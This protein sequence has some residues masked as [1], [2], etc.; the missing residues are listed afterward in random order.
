MQGEDDMDEFISSDHPLVSRVTN[1]I[2]KHFATGVHYL[3][4]ASKSGLT[5]DLALHLASSDPAL[6]AMLEQSKDRTRT[7]AIDVIE[8]PSPKKNRGSPTEIKHG[9][10]KDLAAAGLFAKS[11]K[12]VRAADPDTDIGA[13]VIEG[14]LRFVVKELWPRESQTEHTE[15]IAIE[16]ATEAELEKK[17]ALVRERR[18]EAQKKIISGSEALKERAGGQ[19]ET[20]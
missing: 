20:A 16:H 18:L 14:H 17:L 13:R 2:E 10:L 3:D 11:V 8:E 5:E 15:E 7:T 12:M 1:L 9:Y 4:A 6:R 19:S